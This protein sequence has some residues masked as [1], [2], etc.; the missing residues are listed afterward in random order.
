MQLVAYQNF[1]LWNFRF[2]NSNVMKGINSILLLL[3]LI[4]CS[5]MN[6]S[7]ITSLLKE[8]E[9]KEILFPKNMYFT[10]MLKDTTYYNLSGKYKILSYVDS[11]GCTS[12]KLQL[13]AWDMLIKEIDSLYIGKV[14][15]IFV[16]SPHK[17]KDIHHALLTA[18]FNYPVCLDDQDSIAKLNNFPSD[19]RYHTFLLDNKNKVLAV[20]NPVYNPKVRELYIKILS[21][22]IDMPIYDKKLHTEIT[23]EQ[24]TIDMGYFDWE[25][26]QTVDFVILNKGKECLVINYVTTSCGCTTVEYSREPIQPGKKTSLKV[27]YKSEHPEHFDKTITIHCNAK[28]SPFHLKI[29]GNAE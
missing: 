22:K 27:K 24:E 17:I 16:F 25:Q 9:Q 21:G 26:E 29:S 20:G 12:C 3:M 18:N 2:N 6:D 14:N 28:N 15:F 7:N 1:M 10:T 19:S 8:W 13:P 11:M 5:N 23:F 4:S